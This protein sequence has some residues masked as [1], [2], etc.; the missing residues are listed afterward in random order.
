MP[1]F[2]IWFVVQSLALVPTA[3]YYVGKW[4]GERTSESAE[5]D[6]M[7]TSAAPESRW[8]LAH[9]FVTIGLIL[10]F[11]EFGLTLRFGLSDA[12]LAGVVLLWGIILVFVIVGVIGYYYDAKALKAADAAWQPNPWIWIVGGFIFGQVL[13]MPIYLAR[14]W[15]TVG[16]DWSK[17]PV[18]GGRVSG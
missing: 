4:Y 12:W 17:L 13:V 5:T 15:W 1:V 10:S 3:A 14:R 18:I 11:I 16:L 6:T 2:L 9:F 8:W 7:E